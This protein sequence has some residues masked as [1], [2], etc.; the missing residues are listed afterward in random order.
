MEQIKMIDR[1]E[2]EL[3]QDWTRLA[4]IKSQDEYQK[5]RAEALKKYN[6]LKKTKQFLNL[7]K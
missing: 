3:K 2:Y 1:L 7:I 5:A 6:E 4:S